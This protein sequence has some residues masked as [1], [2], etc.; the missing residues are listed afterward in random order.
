MTDEQKSVILKAISENETFL[1]ALKN[2]F[3]ICF[4]EDYAAEKKQT[5]ELFDKLRKIALRKRKRDNFR[6]VVNSKTRDNLERYCISN[7][8]GGYGIDYMGFYSI[9]RIA[10]ITDERLN[11]NC[12]EVVQITGGD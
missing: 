6:F 8:L 10:V 5:E 12:F 11:D 4:E 9:G 3:G 2:C 1:G 7:V